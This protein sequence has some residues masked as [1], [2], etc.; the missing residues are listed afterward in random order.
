MFKA[1]NEKT[2]IDPVG[3]A[4]RAF[5]QLGAG[6]AA[7]EDEGASRARKLVAL[8]LATLFLIAMPLFWL[9]G[10]GGETAVAS[11]AAKSAPGPGHDGSGHS[12]DDDDDEDNSGPGNAGN[13]G[14]DTTTRGTSRNTTRGDTTR[15]SKKGTDTGTSRGGTQTRTR[16]GTQTRTGAGS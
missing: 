6:E 5:M 9:S 8:G 1:R 4:P 7:L 15:G 14:D 13:R 16:G 2:G 3:A 11:G 10:P 12:G